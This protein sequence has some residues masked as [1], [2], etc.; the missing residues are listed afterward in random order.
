MESRFYGPNRCSQNAVRRF[1]HS[2]RSGGEHYF[3]GR[4]ITFAVAISKRLVGKGQAAAQAAN[5]TAHD[6]GDGAQFLERRIALSSLHSANVT[7]SGVRLQRQFLLGQPF[8]LTRRS[9]PLTEHLQRGGFLQPL[10]AQ[11]GGE[12]SSSHY[13]SDFSACIIS[14]NCDKTLQTPGLVCGRGG[15]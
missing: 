7:R 9:N 13:S 5:V 8:G 6:L 4:K 14:T 1:T 15:I 3:S 2:L 10:Q 12:L 11:P